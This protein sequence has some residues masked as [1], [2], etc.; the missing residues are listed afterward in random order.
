MLIIC[1]DKQL[2][3]HEEG[4]MNECRNRGRVCEQMVTNNY[5]SNEAS[6]LIGGTVLLASVDGGGI[7]DHVSVKGVIDNGCNGK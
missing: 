3:S 6:S 7:M 2:F 5:K 1:A 4:L